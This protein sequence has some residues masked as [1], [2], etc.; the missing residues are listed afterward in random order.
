M[1]TGNAWPCWPWASPPEFL[2]RP[3]LPRLGGG[4][5]DPEE[6]A[7]CASFQRGDRGRISHDRAPGRGSGLAGG[8]PGASPC[9]PA[10][11]RR[12]KREQT[13]PYNRIF[14]LFVFEGRALDLDGFFAF[15]PIH[16]DPSWDLFFRDG[17]LAAP[18]HAMVILPT[19]HPVPFRRAGLHGEW[20][21]CGV[22]SMLR[23]V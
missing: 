7:V 11:G 2:I 14:S 23:V 10:P 18:L 16:W 3:L 5:G 13:A 21:I 17:S 4:I 12:D 19:H 1:K 6:D 15:T 22:E 20:K 9:H 8:L